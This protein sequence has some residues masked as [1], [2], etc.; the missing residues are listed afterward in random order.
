VADEHELM[1]SIGATGLA[2]EAKTQHLSIGADTVA[3]DGQPVRPTDDDPSTPVHGTNSSSIED[4]IAG[5]KLPLVT[6]L[7]Q[8]PPRLSCLTHARRE[9]GV[10]PQRETCRHVRLP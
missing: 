7:I 5:L 10:V 9:L 3:N 8:S 2:L 6:P 4:F 1:L